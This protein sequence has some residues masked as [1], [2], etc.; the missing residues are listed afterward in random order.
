MGPFSDSKHT[1]LGIFIL[2]LPA[3]PGRTDSGNSTR[4]WIRICRQHAIR[5]LEVEGTLLYYSSSLF[6]I[7]F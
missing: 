7:F 5:S 4:A 1:H 3:P 2:E 6:V